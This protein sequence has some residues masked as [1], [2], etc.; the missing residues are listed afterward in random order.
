MVLRGILIFVLLANLNCGSA[1]ECSIDKI[2]NFKVP[3][4]EE[5]CKSHF[6]EFISSLD[7]DERWAQDSKNSK[8]IE[9]LF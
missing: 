2:K 3:E 6:E 4:S 5:L 9:N 8:E 7:T 1:K